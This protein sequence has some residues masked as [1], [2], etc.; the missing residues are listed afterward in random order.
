MK[1]LVELLEVNKKGALTTE[2][3]EL[4]SIF[5]V[6]YGKDP[7]NYEEVIPGI[8]A[9][10]NESTEV[11]KYTT[12]VTLGNSHERITGA[13][14]LEASVKLLN[15]HK[16]TAKPDERDSLIFKDLL[17]VE[18]LLVQH[19]K[20]QQPLLKSKIA[21]SMNLND[22]VRSVISAATFTKPIKNFFTT[23]D[24]TNT[25]EQTNPVKIVSD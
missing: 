18:D 9:Y 19:F 11:D 10:F 16:G 22:D 24:M 17:G 8:V 1:D 3:S 7:T 14:L 13:L 2:S 23:G 4:S 21:R 25:P 12:K 5:K 15:I 20:K 6:L